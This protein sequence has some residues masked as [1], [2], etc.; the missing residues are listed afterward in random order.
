MEFL[1]L[2]SPQYGCLTVRF[3]GSAVKDQPLLKL[4]NEYSVPRQKAVTVDVQIRI[5]CRSEV[6]ADRVLGCDVRVKEA[7]QLLSL[8]RTQVIHRF[9][10]L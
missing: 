3:S 1:G 5:V 8:G 9:P 10:M 6:L 2:L 4:R 7:T